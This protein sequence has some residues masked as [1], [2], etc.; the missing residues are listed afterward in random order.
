S[1]LK[2][3]RQLADVLFPRTVLNDRLH[4]FSTYERMCTALTAAQVFDMKL[5]VTHSQF[6]VEHINAMT[7]LAREHT[8]LTPDLAQR[9]LESCE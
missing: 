5:W 7:T 1:W 4:T 6:I 8:M 3:A 9:Y 2:P